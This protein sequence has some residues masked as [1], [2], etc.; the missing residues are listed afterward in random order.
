MDVGSGVK[1][2]RCTLRQILYPCHASRVSR[3]LELDGRRSTS[4]EGSDKI[5]PN[6]G[7]GEREDWSLHAPRSAHASPC[8][9]YTVTPQL[10]LPLHIKRVAHISPRRFRFTTITVDVHG[11]SE[12]GSLANHE[13]HSSSASSAIPAGGGAASWP[14]TAPHCEASHHTCAGATLR[15]SGQGRAAKTRRAVA[16]RCR[17]KAAPCSRR[18]RRGPTRAATARR[19][20]RPAAVHASRPRTACLVR[21][22]VGLG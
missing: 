3:E 17:P 13:S 1:P 10:E 2:K 18:R 9:D 4:R 16:P 11:W 22:R 7:S 6:A 8:A 15:V 19:A 5:K 12:G 20:A 21:A 14:C